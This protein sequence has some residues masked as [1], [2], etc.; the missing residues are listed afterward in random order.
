LEANADAT[1][2]SLLTFSFLHE[3]KLH[4]TR[5]FIWGLNCGHKKELT[6]HK[7]FANQHQSSGWRGGSKVVAR[8]LKR[9]YNW[10]GADAIQMEPYLG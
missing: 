7:P 8:I 9:G 3:R 1:P 5:K 2:P 4:G 10:R 6:E